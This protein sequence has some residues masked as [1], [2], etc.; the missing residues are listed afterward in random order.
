MRKVFT[1]ISIILGLQFFGYAC[2]CI[3]TGSFCESVRFWKNIEGLESNVVHAI[4]AEKDETGIKITVLQTYYGN[5]TAGTMFNIRNGSVLDCTISTDALDI[6]K[7]YIFALEF[8]ASQIQQVSNCGTF[9]LRV[10]DGKAKGN[11]A[12][13]ID[14]ASLDD[15]VKLPN[16]GDFQGPGL[17]TFRLTP[18]LVINEE[19]RAFPNFW[20]EPNDVEIQIFDINGR[21]MLNTNQKNFV[22]FE[23]I[24]ISTKDWPAGV[25]CC[26]FIYLGKKQ[27]IRIVK[28]N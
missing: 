11:I 25:Y 20:L 9:Y 19:L 8:P 22:A 2:S 7:T 4:V 10:E 12:P 27:T 28:V 15:F 14:E 24:E 1:T 5:A 16:C 6:G 21:L 17:P 23:P 3:D 13:G 26:Q 18:T